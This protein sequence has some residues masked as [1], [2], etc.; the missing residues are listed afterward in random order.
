MLSWFTIILI[1]ISLSLDTF[2]LSLIYGTLPFDKRK[3]ILLSLTVGLYHFFMPL[4]GSFIGNITLS[5]LFIPAHYIV[6]F[7]LLIVSIEMLISSF[8]EEKVL[9]LNYLGILLFG[10]AVS[11]DSFLTGIGLSLIYTNIIYCAFIFSLLSSFFTTFGLLLGRHLNLLLG[12]LATI[13]GSLCL[14]TIAIYY[15]TK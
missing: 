10:L 3:V 8:K 13:I 6:G 4:M 5:S 15:L 7:L 11:I 1:G 2:S 12:R 9:T 14:L